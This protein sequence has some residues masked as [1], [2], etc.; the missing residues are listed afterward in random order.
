LAATD[1]KLLACVVQLR[2]KWRALPG[3][4][5]AESAGHPP[6]AVLPRDSL[7]GLTDEPPLFLSLEIA[8]AS[9]ATEAI[10]CR[11]SRG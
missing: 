3:Q 11:G 6:Q 8:S 2:V 1:D 9:E 7:F 4:A 5:D 10:S